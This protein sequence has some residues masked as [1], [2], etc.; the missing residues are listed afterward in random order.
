MSAAVASEPIQFERGRY[1]VESRMVLPHL[2]EMR[3]MVTLHEVCLDKGPAILQLFPVTGQPALRGRQLV[4]P[5]N[6]GT[7]FSLQCN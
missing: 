5:E 3:R 2:D 4:A 1:V 7:N 6:E